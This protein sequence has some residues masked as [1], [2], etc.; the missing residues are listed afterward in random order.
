MAQWNVEN[1]LSEVASNGLARPCRFEVSID[2]PACVSN[3]E[4]TRLVSMFCEQALL[5]QMRIL[6]SRQQLFG[7][8]SLHP[9]GV[10]FGGDNLTLNFFVDRRMKVKQ[11]FDSWMQGIIAPSTYTANYQNNYLTSIY[12]SQLDEADEAQYS[13]KLIDAF[14]IGQA[15]LQLDFN[16]RDTVHRLPVT[17]AY[18]NWIQAQP[19]GS[20]PGQSQR[21]PQTE[22]TRTQGGLGQVRPQRGVP[23]PRPQSLAPQTT[24]DTQA[25]FFI[26]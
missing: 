21:Q 8:P 2:S 10:D 14:P 13:I 7:P 18:R 3:N 24:L 1:F 20:S 12:I 9:T 19:P 22:I 26:K 17:F 16:Q 5:P 25:D 23:M 6:T 4:G 11:F 15:P